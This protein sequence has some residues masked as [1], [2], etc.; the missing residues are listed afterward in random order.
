MR[1]LFAALTVLSLVLRDRCLHRSG[2][3]G[4]DLLFPPNEN[5][6]GTNS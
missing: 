4:H 2:Q 3:G 1:K 5:G 6:G